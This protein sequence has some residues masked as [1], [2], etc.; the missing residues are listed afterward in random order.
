[1]QVR[2]IDVA[3]LLDGHGSALIGAAGMAG[4]V[5]AAGWQGEGL[6]LAADAVQK[7]GLIQQMVGDDMGDATRLLDL[8]TADQHLGGKYGAAQ[9][10]E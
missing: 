4:F 6:V 2:D 3:D 5:A 9:L 10:V 8:P 1:M 7:F